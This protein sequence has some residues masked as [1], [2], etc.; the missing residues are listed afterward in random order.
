MA[1]R[2]G[3]HFNFGRF[4]HQSRFRGAINAASIAHLVSSGNS[5]DVR[6]KISGQPCYVFYYNRFRVAFG[7]L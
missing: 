4:G 7:R 1:F 3:L 2:L 6:M 5:Q